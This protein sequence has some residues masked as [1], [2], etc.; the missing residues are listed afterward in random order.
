VA[1]VPL[2]VDLIAQ[3]KDLLRQGE[4]YIGVRTD[5]D[6]W[7][8]ASLFSS[9][10][11]VQLDDDGSVMGVVIG[12][13]SQDDPDDVYVQDVMVHP[14][15]RGRRVAA[16]LLREVAQAAGQ[17]GCRRLYLTSEPD[18]EA[19]ARTWAKLGF[20][21]VPGDLVQHGVQ[22]ISDFKGPGKHRAVYELTLP[23]VE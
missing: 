21:N 4:P 9:T 20:V 11:P 22:V 3:V 19:A 2:A 6:Y 14:H 16:D 8:Y 12:F 1:I 23:H 5:S 13:R 7:L 17:W 18:N 15:H 10:C